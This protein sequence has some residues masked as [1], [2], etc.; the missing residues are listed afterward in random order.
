MLM[1]DA[2]TPNSSDVADARQTYRDA[3]QKLLELS[4]RIWVDGQAAVDGLLDIAEEH[5]T[6]K[7]TLAILESP[8]KFSPLQDRVTDSSFADASETLETLIEQVM[9]ARDGLDQATAKRDIALRATDAMRLPVVNFGGREFVIDVRKGELRAVDD[10]SERY[11]LADDM[12]QP[13]PPEQSKSSLTQ[14]IAKDTGIEPA[15][16]G[17]HPDRTRSR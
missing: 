11:R 5:G 8:E 17:P 12:V 7:A 13:R 2:P 14:Q 4:A 15:K 6:D 10:A 16:P 1:T 9:V 3:E